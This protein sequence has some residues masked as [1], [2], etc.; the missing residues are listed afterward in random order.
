MY[1]D[2][3]YKILLYI[4]MLHVKLT[5]EAVDLASQNFHWRYTS[6]I[7]NSAMGITDTRLRFIL[8][9]FPKKSKSV[10]N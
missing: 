3:F 4:Y 9:V 10:V 5:V 1:K 7:L 2:N 8:M 6:M